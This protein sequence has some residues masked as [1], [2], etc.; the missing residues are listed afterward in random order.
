MITKSYN[1]INDTYTVVFSLPV[2]VVENA[3]EVKVLG[4]FNDW[5][6][7]QGVLLTQSAETLEARIELSPGRQYEF[8]YVSDGYAQWFND[9]AADSY[10][11]SPFW[12]V[13]NC[14]V[15]LEKHAN[16]NGTVTDN[17]EAKTRR[18]KAD[19]P[20][21]DD[22]KKIEGIGPKIEGLLH[23][24]GIYTFAQLAASKENELRGI[25]TEAGP[26]FKMHNPASWMEQASLA[27][28]GDWDKLET[29]QDSL[30]GGV[31]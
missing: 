2:G 23:G 14:V 8:R 29:L 7:N 30:K 21:G 25:L 11:P 31:A 13:D 12:G 6:W 9:A 26:R 5:D 22:L 20:A 28:V 19:K 3:T 4:D 24:K 10:V 27:A 18:K 1:P 15:V 16:G 17:T